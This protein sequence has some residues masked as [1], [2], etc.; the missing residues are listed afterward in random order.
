MP[1]S[2]IRLVDSNLWLALSFSDH[3]H[4]RDAVAWFGALRE[5]EAAFC[6]ITQ[7]ALLRHLT[8]VAIMREFVLSQRTAWECYE[9]LRRDYRVSFLN[10]PPDLNARW[11][12]LTSSDKPRHRIWTD[13]YL[14]AFASAQGVALA[15]A[16]RDFK[17]FRGL[18]LDFVKTS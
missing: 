2:G 7:M 3:A 4:H 18:A 10:E 1:V 16:D 11:R 8:N 17:A 5:R 14:A 13:A 9:E 6:R 12:H 15:T